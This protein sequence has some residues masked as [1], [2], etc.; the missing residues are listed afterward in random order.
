MHLCAYLYIDALTDRQSN[1]TI[2]P[3]GEHLFLRNRTMTY[4]T[5]NNTDLEELFVLLIDV[6]SSKDNESH[7]IKVLFYTHSTLFL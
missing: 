7:I 5:N 6:C 2:Y 4:I 3:V 1:S